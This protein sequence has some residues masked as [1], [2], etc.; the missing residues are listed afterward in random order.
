MKTDR[1]ARSYLDRARERLRA[2]E[3]SFQH[4]SYP[5][6]VR[7]TQE[8][9]EMSLKSCLRAVGIEHPKSHDVG[10]FLP[11]ARDRLPE[12]F[13]SEADEYP[14]IS[15]ELASLRSVSLYGIEADGKTPG[16]MFTK[17]DAE[18]A[19]EWARRV[20]SSVARLITE[21]DHT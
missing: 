14:R 5:D 12:W 3:S 11:Y 1:L 8:C 7:F 21:L 10:A 16:E 6:V 20:Y 13:R 15:A 19:L 2:A 18:K 17:P 4:D 9:V